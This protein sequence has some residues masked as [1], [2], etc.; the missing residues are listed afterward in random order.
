MRLGV[1]RLELQVE[2]LKDQVA[3]LD[4]RCVEIEGRRARLEP[5]IAD[6][7]RAIRPLR[8]PRAQLPQ[9]GTESA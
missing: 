7:N 6:V 5:Y 9:R 1:E 4:T 8:R 2:G 3:S